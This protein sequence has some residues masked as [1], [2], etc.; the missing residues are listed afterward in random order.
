M[1]T[2]SKI[3]SQLSAQRLQQMVLYFMAGSVVGHYFEIVW[4]FFRDH[5]DDPSYIV[6]QL[7]TVIPPPLAE[8]YGFGAV[9]IVLLVV[10]LV[11]R[12]KLGVVKTYLLSVLVVSVVEYLC[13]AILVLLFGHNYFWNYSGIPF[14]VQGYINLA[15]SLAFGVGATLFVFLLYPACER[16]LQRLNRNQLRVTSSVL[17]VLYIVDVVFIKGLF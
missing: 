11:E 13:A 5:L 4:H 3:S 7:L 14:N 16:A 2:Y 8:P 12:Y 9:A 10:P 6:N 1:D 15:T 17:L